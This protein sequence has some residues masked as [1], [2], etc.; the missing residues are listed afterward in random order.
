MT[1]AVKVGGERLYQQGAS[2]R[3][4]GDARSA[5]SK[6]LRAQ[7]LEREGRRAPAIEIECSSGTYVRTLIET[8]GDAYCESLRRIAVGPLRVEDAGTELAPI[9]ALSFLPELR[10]DAEQAE[11]VRM[12]GRSSRLRPGEATGP[13]QLRGR[14]AR[15]RA[16]RGGPAATRGRA[17]VSI[18][19]TTLADAEPRDRAGRDR[20]LRRRPPRPPGGD[21]RRRHGAHLRSASARGPAPGRSAEA[22]HA[23]RGQA[24][25][26]R[27]H[28][29]AGAGRDPLRPRLLR[30][31]GRAAS[32]KT[33]CSSA[34]GAEAG[35]GRARTSASAP[36][37]RATP[38]CCAA[39]PEFETRV[40]PLV[41]VD[42]E[43]VSSTR[44]RALVAAGD[45][46]AARSLPGRPVHGRGHGRRGRPARPRARLPD[47]QP[48][49]RRPPGH[50]PGTAS[51]RRSRTAIPAAVNIGVRP[52]FETGRGVLIE[53]YLIDHDV[54]LYGQVLRV[55][56]VARLRGE[57]RFE[58]RG[59]DRADELDVEGA[60]GSV[61]AS[62]GLRPR[63][64]TL[65]LRRLRRLKH[66]RRTLCRRRQTP[67]CHS[68]RTRKPS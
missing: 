25:R 52:T 54:D 38:R 33:C 27:R 14:P 7:L 23:V 64:P 29:R 58:R 53:S 50:R 36:R 10:L 18:K 28:R 66:L 16:A 37:P 20:D 17:G 44:I 40:V 31:P 24:R 45:I 21:R 2:R 15:R 42:G 9:D 11:A 60:R 3:D 67:Q 62:S 30:D 5:R 48:G 12:E 59:A 39:R 13:A 63:G 68:P 57:R 61:L 43:T 26:D 35:L 19:V 1:S 55:A 46:E 65:T 22:D 8:L 6:S 56:F 4:R 34:L 49:S 32:S 47:R 41:E 51:T